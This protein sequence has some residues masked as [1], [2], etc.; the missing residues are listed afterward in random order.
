[1]VLRRIFWN[2]GRDF[3]IHVE[4]NTTSR[5][6]DSLLVIDDSV[7]G[8]G[9]A[10]APPAGYAVSFAGL[11][12]GAPAAHGVRVDAGTGAVTAT[13]P[14]PAPKLRNFIV[15]AT[16]TD[17]AATSMTLEIRFHIHESVRK[18]WAT[19]A[20]LTVRQNAEDVRLT[21]LAEFDDGTVGDVT[22]WANLPAAHTSHLAWSAATS[23]DVDAQADGRILAKTAGAARTVT[24]RLGPA[25]AP[26]NMRSTVTITVAPPW[27]NPT[28]LTFIDGAGA[29]RFPSVPNILLLPDGFT[30]RADFERLARD[31]VLKLS[32]RHSTRP[33]DLL[34]DS[35]NYWM[36]WVPSPQDGVSLVS[37]M[38]EVL[39]R[40]G[41]TRRSK[42]VPY[43]LAPPA[44][45]A[46]WT[47]EQM[48]HEVGLPVAAYAGRPLTGGA[49][50][51]LTEL[52][53]LYGPHVTNARISGVYADWLK[54]HERTLLN[55][56][57]TA[58]GL[59]MGER[60]RTR[61]FESHRGLGGYD[62][63]LSDADLDRFLNAL[64]HAA[65]AVGARWVAGNAPG[66]ARGPD[67]GLVGFLSLS[68]RG[69]GSQAENFYAM[70][71]AD[72]TDVTFQ[73]VA[74]G[75]DPSTLTPVPS[76]A[77]AIVVARTAHESAHAF[78]LQDEYGGNAQLTAGRTFPNH[79][80]VQ[81]EASVRAGGALSGA[82]I[83]WQ[84]PR[85]EAA[86]VLTAPPA[87]I[88]PMPGGFTLTLGAG[89]A[90]AFTVGDHVFLR[91]RPLVGST[92]S[93]RLEITAIVADNLTV[94]DASSTL[95][96]AAFPGGSIVFRPKLSVGA[97]RV[98]RSLVAPRIAAHITSSGNPL[99]AAAA[100]A[101]GAVCV[102][103]ANTHMPAVNIPAAV[104]AQISGAR[105]PRY[106]AWLVG[107]YEGGALASCGIYHPTGTCL[108]RSKEFYAG[109]SLHIYQFCTVC[110]YVMVDRLD[111][112]KHGII[113]ADYDPRY[114]DP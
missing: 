77:S 16:V 58:F 96:A 90:A 67:R 46:T 109:G 98:E 61:E 36:A 50:P 1:V 110:R 93:V 81:E 25:P 44:G 97:P 83:K 9:F 47:L 84:W 73:I 71:V 54:L 8:T 62:R 34:K 60:P 52:R 43:P 18:I 30:A 63:R 57:N 37:E 27:S 10:N 75:A 82:L 78:G 39:A 40:S 103:N 15:R 24:V 14:V 72:A 80:N 53:T 104:A 86:G 76:A 107:L 91:T 6:L 20:A 4:R 19:P 32:T 105:R 66:L 51:M 49:T 29:A 68:R 45:A 22:E 48:I 3:D 23:A 11:F 7:A 108:M 5:T 33:F 31:V 95:N 114:P 55:E 41:A 56:R 101:A 94:V 70:A 99:N 17:A 106:S 100:A 28:A 112:T 89:H 12:A 65:G 64:T 88:V 111:P 42:E 13:T 2:G 38:G 74:N 113:D 92:R 35:I 102:P 87:R 85:I 26:A 69:G 59:R 21:V 79:G